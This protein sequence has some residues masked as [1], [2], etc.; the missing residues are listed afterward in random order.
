MP[1]ALLMMNEKPINIAL[2]EGNRNISAATLHLENITKSMCKLNASLKKV[3]GLQKFSL[4]CAMVE[5]IADMET[6]SQ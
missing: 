5:E 6:T 4:W 2:S 1:Y 3:S